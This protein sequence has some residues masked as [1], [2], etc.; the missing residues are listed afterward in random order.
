MAQSFAAGRRAVEAA[1]QL[2]ADRYRHGTEGNVQA[3][4]VAL[5]R[6]LQVGT[7][8]SHYQQGSDQADIYLPNRR[9]FIECKAYPKAAHPERKAPSG[10]QES[11]REQVERYVHAEIEF[12]SQLLPGLS[13]VPDAPWRGIVTDGTNWH[14]YLY[15]HKSSAKGVLESTREFS[16][17]GD[18]LA[19]FLGETL[20]H[21]QTGKE[22][23]PDEPG[24]LFSDLKVDLDALYER[25]PKKA[26]QPTRTKRRLWL[27]MME[28]S[29]M[30]PADEAGQERLFL[31]FR[32]Y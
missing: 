13:N 24:E 1:R 8:E 21:E 10:K 30:V 29:G 23:I 26:T 22:W 9:T 31:V 5:L 12:E 25:L 28:T 15:P 14:V 11:P 19:A 2:L 32:Q 18:A 4:I 3:D 6:E 27:D 16:N 7:I 17:E 20:G